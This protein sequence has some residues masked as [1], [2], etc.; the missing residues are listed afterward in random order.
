MP[1]AKTNWELLRLVGNHRKLVEDNK[2]KK[3][4]NWFDPF[5]S[6]IDLKKD[7][8]RKLRAV[9]RKSNAE[10]LIEEGNVPLITI[11]GMTPQEY[12]TGD[13]M[14]EVEV[15]NAGP[16]IGIDVDAIL[17][18]GIFKIKSN[19][20][21]ASL[22]SGYDTETR[23]SRKL[24]FSLSKEQ[25]NALHCSFIMPASGIAPAQWKVSISS[26]TTQG[27]VFTDEVMLEVQK[28]GLGIEERK[29]PWY[30]GKSVLL[31]KS[32]LMRDSNEEL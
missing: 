11:V 29:S 28:K 8:S 15:A 2:S 6:S 31:S 26:M 24:R 18:L 5:T 19:N 21:I 25:Y 17:D 27:H 7:L 3:A 23:G 10:R 22:P 20:K 4:N 13:A 16:V 14:Y 12:E 9:V 1:W 30:C 32:L